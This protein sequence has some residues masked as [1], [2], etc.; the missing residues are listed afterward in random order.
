[1]LGALTIAAAL[2]MMTACS[3][4]DNFM[5]NPNM[6]P[7]EAIGVTVT[8]SAGISDGALTRSK[9]VTEDGKRVLTFT[10]GDQLYVYGEIDAS[11]SVAGYLTMDGAPTNGNKSATF[12]GTVKAYDISGSTPVE[13]TMPAGDDPLALCTYKTVKATLVHKDLNTEAIKITPGA[14]VGLYTHFMHAATVEELMTTGL[15]AQG[16]YS[17]G[18]KSFKLT[19]ECPIF[20]CTISGLVAGRVY[21]IGLFYETPSVW[22]ES[23]RDENFTADA[24]G[25][26]KVAFASWKSGNYHW[27]INVYHKWDYTEPE[28]PEFDKDIDL[29]T[30]ELTAKVY[31]V[32][33]NFV[34]LKALAADYEAKSGDVLYGATTEHKVT[35]ADGATVTLAGVNIS[36]TP[37]ACIQCL[38]SATILLVDETT[39]TLECNGNYQAIWAGDE[40]TTL[41]IQ[42]SGTLNAQ[43]GNGAAGIG[44]GFN[45]SNKT[46]G[47]IVIKG[48]IINAI[49]GTGGAGIGSDDSGKCGSID[50]TGGTITATGGDYAAGIGSGWKSTTYTTSC[51]IITITDKVTKVTA[52]KGSSAPNSIG[53]GLDATCSGVLIGGLGYSGISTSPYTYQP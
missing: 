9:V 43:G 52:T 8:V 40:G 17:S 30:R 13:T 38:G 41:T 34:D 51:G 22:I 11:T 49:G 6:V 21:Q 50:I 12:T 3:S 1:M 5:E 28:I 25:V 53:A 32:T 47:D 24:N 44:G 37:G 26:I 4:E 33:R 10:T 45:N 16:D 31:N 29:G 15:V 14:N 19:S 18:T 7:A 36:S 46:C 35:I 27:K 48:G 2:T 20:N 42:G 23:F 39:N